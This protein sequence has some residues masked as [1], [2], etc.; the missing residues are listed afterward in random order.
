ML[1][2]DRVSWDLVRDCL[3]LAHEYNKKRG[4]NMHNPTMTAQELEDYLKGSYCFVAMDGED[5]V[6]TC[7]LK[8]IKSDSWWAKGEYVAYSC[9]D[10]ILPQYKGTD[11]FFDLKNM[12][13]DYVKRAG[14]KIMQFD[15]HIDNKL[16]QKMSL[17]FGYKYV[18]YCA[19]P[20]TDYYSVVMVK[21]FDG[22][23][24]SDRYCNFRYNLSKF[25]TKLLFK[26][27]RKFKFV[28]FK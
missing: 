4:F 9:L 11:V 20:M 5:V 24:F 25:L 17:R 10:G 21:W 8:I 27:G 26:P 15:T 19:F 6:G 16:V 3:I 23:P 28:F 22:C 13:L 12:R 7:S 2:P 1:K 14:I 18:R